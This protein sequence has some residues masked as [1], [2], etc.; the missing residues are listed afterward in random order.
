M[1]VITLLFSFLLVFTLSADEITKLD[2]QMN[3]AQKEQ[4]INMEKQIMAACCFGGPLHSHNRN[5]YTEEERLEIRQLVLQGQSDN[6]ILDYFRHKI[7]PRTGMPYGNRI[8]AA[9]KSDE[10]VGQV[11][12]WMVVVFAVIG[13]AVLWF[14]LKILLGSRV[15]AA[16]LPR[17]PT[18]KDE[19][20]RK[21]LA[22][23]EKE[24]KALDKD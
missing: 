4:T 21:I 14:T 7:D 12:Y 8:L 17:V 23:V 11:S 16:R 1:K 15:N 22:K 20:N 5:D 19:G 13:A 6:Q 3:P 9:P 24:L 10:F 2:N 18:A